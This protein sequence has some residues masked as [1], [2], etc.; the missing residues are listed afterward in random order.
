MMEP[1]EAD[2]SQTQG[3]ERREEVKA[4]VSQRHAPG[5]KQSH[6]T[7]RQWSLNK[8]IFLVLVRRW[9]SRHSGAS[10][11][12]NGG[13]ISDV[14]PVQW[15]FLHLSQVVRR[16]VNLFLLVSSISSPPLL[17]LFAPFW[18]VT[19][20]GESLATDSTTAA[21]VVPGFAT[22]KKREKRKYDLSERSK[23]KANWVVVI[24]C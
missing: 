20:P 21:P 13:W 2:K 18:M 11:E 22:K 5:E 6:Q 15:F 8:L 23:L 17:L 19:P 9:G 3:K 24:F 12:K 1:G 7:G 4:K 16:L 10:S 14:P